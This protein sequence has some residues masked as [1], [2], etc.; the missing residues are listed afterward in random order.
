MGAGLVSMSGYM[1]LLSG[2]CMLLVTVV[3]FSKA[4]ARKFSLLQ[5]R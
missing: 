4:L 1:F 5:L 2:T 3:D